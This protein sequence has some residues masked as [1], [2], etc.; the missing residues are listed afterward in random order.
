MITCSV[1][2]IAYNEEQ[3][4]AGLIDRI[5]QQ[6]LDSV[7]IKEII[8]VASGCTD[9]TLQIAREH[10]LV[11][12]RVIVIKEKERTGKWNAINLFIQKASTNVLVMISADVLPLETTVQKLVAPFYNPLVGMTGSHVIPKNNP[13]SFMGYGV[14]FFWRMFDIVSRITP[15]T[16]EMVAFRKVFNSMPANAVDEACIEFLIKQKNFS[17]K[18]IPDAIVLNKGPETV[19]DF[20]SQRRRIWWGYFHFVHETNGEFSFV[21]PSFFKMVGLVIKTTEWNV[22][23]I[24][25]V[26]VFIVIEAIG[27]I[28]GWW[29]YTIAKKNHLIWRMAQT[30]KEHI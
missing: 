14:H 19:G 15:K 27:R 9:K 12:E 28:L 26:P 3:N 4:I 20:L 25:H 5:F 29:D 11:D 21:S 8:I 1:G 30:T 10:S 16:G 24:T 23:A 22:Q 2:I 18:Y 7:L 6:K 13:N 17:V